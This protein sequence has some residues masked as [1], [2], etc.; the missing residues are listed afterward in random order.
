M[1]IL[2]IFFVFSSGD[3]KH[4]L[5]NE[6]QI[7]A[8]KMLLKGW[9]TGDVDDS[10]SFQLCFQLTEFGFK[11]SI[12]GWGLQCKNCEFQTV[13]DVLGGIQGTLKL[14]HCK[15]HWDKSVCVVFM[16]NTAHLQKGC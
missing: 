11:L 16:Y 7:P 10:V 6:L 5:E 13:L 2:Y 14:K 15:K 8:S 4:I 9:K 1:Y 12:C 3:I